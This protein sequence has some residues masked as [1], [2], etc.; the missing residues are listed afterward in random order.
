MENPALAQDS[1]YRLGAC[2]GIFWD[3]VKSGLSSESEWSKVWICLPSR[4]E[5]TALLREKSFRNGSPFGLKEGAT[6]TQ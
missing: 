1:W 6:V 4:M 3:Y 2:V 5:L